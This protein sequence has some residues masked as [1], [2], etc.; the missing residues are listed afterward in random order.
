V[1]EEPTT[2]SGHPSTVLACKQWGVIA[3]GG[4]LLGLDRYPFIKLDNIS[5]GPKEE[6]I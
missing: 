2:I 5:T 1:T 6:A 4:R 3:I